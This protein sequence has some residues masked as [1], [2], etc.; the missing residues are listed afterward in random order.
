MTTETTPAVEPLGEKYL[1]QR[2]DD[3]DGKHDRCRF[4]VL[5][6][7]HDEHAR[8]ALAFYAD[9]VRAT[10]PQLADDLTAWVGPSRLD[11]EEMARALLAHQPEGDDSEDG[12]YVYIGCVC[13]WTDWNASDRTWMHSQSRH[14]ATALRAALIGGAR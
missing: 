10:N 13:G 12:D 11:V 3:P 6:P 2:R 5:D 8:T 7:Q 1:V 14:Q 4:F 9:L